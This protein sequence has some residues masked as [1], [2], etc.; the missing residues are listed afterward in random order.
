MIPI[1][2]GMADMRGLALQAQWEATV[3][4]ASATCHW[5]SL[6]CT[7]RTLGTPN[8]FL[9]YQ[10]HGKLFCLNELHNLHAYHI[11]SVN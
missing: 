4:L 6:P 5:K 8:A 9:H 2:V 7:F 1:R 11:Y 10:N 3:W